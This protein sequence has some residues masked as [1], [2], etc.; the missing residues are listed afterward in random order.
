MANLAKVLHDILHINQMSE[1]IRFVRNY[2]GKVKV[3]GMFLECFSLKRINASDISSDILNS[4]QCE[5]FDPMTCR[6]Q[7]YDDATIM[8]G[9]HDGVQIF[10]KRKNKK[11][12]CDGCMDHSLSLCGQHSFA[13][14]I[15][16]VT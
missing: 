6:A 3:R 15:S 5:M 14:N 8:A 4:F 10:L 16:H 7:G 1:M 2:N 9:I 13:E 12:N 11:A